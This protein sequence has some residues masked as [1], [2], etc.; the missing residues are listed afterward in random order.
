MSMLVYRLSFGSG[1]GCCRVFNNATL[2]FVIKD[3]ELVGT[4]G[5]HILSMRDATR[6]GLCP[7][8]GKWRAIESVKDVLS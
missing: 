4:S 2:S 7:A 5:L 3:G 8:R 1:G 6:Q